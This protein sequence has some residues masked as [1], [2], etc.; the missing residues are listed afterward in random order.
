MADLVLTPEPTKSGVP[1][2]SNLASDVPDNCEVYVFYVPGMTSYED[3]KTFLLDYGKSA[4][5]NIFVGL[6]DLS[7]VSLKEILSDFQIRG[8]PAVIVFANPKDS[9]D[10]QFPPRTAYA[11][12][13]A[14]AALSLNQTTVRI[15]LS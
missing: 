12:I 6:W 13:D 3:L 7:A 8:S 11:R 5:T 9:T 10:G 2:L 1:H 14:R 4:G 15:T